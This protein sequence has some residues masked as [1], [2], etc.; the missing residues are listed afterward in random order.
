MRLQLIPNRFAI[1]EA[2]Y[3]DLSGFQADKPKKK[4]KTVTARDLCERADLYAMGVRDEWLES[5]KNMLLARF[6]PEVLDKRFWWTLNRV[7]AVDLFCAQSLDEDWDEAT[8]LA[9][10]AERVAYGLAVLHWYRLVCQDKVNDLFDFTDA[11]CAAWLLNYKPPQ[12]QNQPQL[13]LTL[14]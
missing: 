9:E 12:P 5:V 13:Q 7:A 11:E 14:F 8:P 6:Q 3:L 10:W 1:L 4:L 2:A